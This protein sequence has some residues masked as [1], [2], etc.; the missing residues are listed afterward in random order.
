[1]ISNEYIIEYAISLVKKYNTRNPFEI[2]K[3]LGIN[4]IRWDG[5][6]RLKGMYKVIKRN[7]YIFINDNLDENMS[8]IVCAHEIGHD[9]FHRALGENAMLSET[10]LYDMTSR[11]EFEANLFASELLLDTDEVLDLVYNY[12]YN[13]TQIAIKLNSDENLVAMKI[14]NLNRNGYKFREP[15]IKNNFLK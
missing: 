14:A 7:R 1:M 3:S 12:D 10:M 6:S 4:V 13:A 5:F 15:P 9:L 8:K 11:P 2:A